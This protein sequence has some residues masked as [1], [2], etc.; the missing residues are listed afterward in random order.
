MALI[1]ENGTGLAGAESYISVADAD[2]YFTARGN[3]TWAALTTE[4][5]EQALR[6]A[7]D[8]MQGM[9]AGQWAGQRYSVAQA[10]DWPRAYVPIKDAPAS[11][12]YYESDEVPAAIGRACAEYAVRASAGSLLG[13]IGAQ[14]KSETVG[15]ISVTYADGARQNSRYTAVENML[16]PFLSGGRGQIKVE[17][18]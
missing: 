15:P 12:S 6:A 1:V 14:V 7:T 13:D 4:Q 17:R 3:A 16:W 2:T 10:L 5:K 8:Y 18:A 11:G 9:F